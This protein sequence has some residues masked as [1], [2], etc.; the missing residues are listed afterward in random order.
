MNDKAQL[1]MMAKKYKAE[2][3]RLYGKSSSRQVQQKNPRVNVPQVQQIQQQIQQAQQQISASETAL[4]QNQKEN[5]ENEAKESEEFV[6]P[7]ECQ[8][9]NSDE[10]SKFPS[11]DEILAAQ[12]ISPSDN[13]VDGAAVPDKTETNQT[14]V[15]GNYSAPNEP[16]MTEKNLLRLP[17]EIT[18]LGGTGY[19]IAEVTDI[20]SAKPVNRAEVVVTK[21]TSDGEVI[22]KQLATNAEGKTPQ[23]YLPT[24]SDATVKEDFNVGIYAAGFCPMTDIVVPIYNAVKSIQPVTLIPNTA[25]SFGNP[26]M[27]FPQ[28]SDTV[29]TLG[30]SGYFVYILQAMICAIGQLY[31]N[32][33]MPPVTGIYDLSTRDAV[34]QLQS[35]AALETTGSVNLKTWNRLASLYNISAPYDKLENIPAFS[36]VQVPSVG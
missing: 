10:A 13:S 7:K 8:A 19:L 9:S 20:A 25:Q 28:N 36:D 23:I 16:E 6:M 21:Q 22:L 32:I 34:R 12:N 11:P 29:V 17:P 18:A 3:M 30:D 24:N 26:I 15:Q 1:D 31:G 5:A 35:V 2:M 4:A 33:L 14:H 27:P